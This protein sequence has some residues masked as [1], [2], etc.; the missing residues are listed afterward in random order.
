MDALRQNLRFGLRQ[1]WRSPLFTVAAVATLAL[2]IGANTALFTL[3]S[4]IMTKPLPGIGAAEQLVWIMAVDRDSRPRGLSYPDFLDYRNGLAGVQL[5]ATSEAEF[6]VS[7]RG[8]PERVSG[9]AVSGNYF[10]TVR[11]PFA[12]GRGFIPGEDSIGN[13]QPVVVLS[14]S[15][16]LRRFAGDSSVVG[17]RVTVNGMPLT[18]VG[19]VAEGFNGADIESPR[20][21]WIPMATYRLLNPGFSLDGRRSRWMK[22]LGRMPDGMTPAQLDPAVRTVAA[23]IAA[24]DSAGHFGMT[25]RA[26]SAKAGLPP[27]AEHE[28]LPVAILAT[29]VTGLVLLIACANVSNLLLARGV[30]RRREIGIRLSIGATRWRLVSQLLT[31]SLL[32]AAL[33]AA[34]GV[35][36]AY[37]STDYLLTSGIL[38]LVFDV[39][40]DTRVVLFT[41]GAAAL[42]AVMFGLVPAIE[43]TRTNLV[44]AVKDGGSGRDPRRSRLQSTFVVAQLSLS[45]VLLTTAGLFLRSLYKANNVDIGYD[46]T[47]RV[48]ALSFDL[49]LQGYSESRANAFL[50][51]IGTRASGL[52][53]V[54]G[55]SFTDIPPMGNRYNIGSLHLDGDGANAQARMHVNRVSVRPGYFT[56]IGT[57]LMRG[58]DF[59]SSDDRGAPRVVIVSQD[60]AAQLWPGVD[61]IGKR[62]GLQGAEGPMVT[63]VGVAS[64]VML[65]GPTEDQRSTVY[66]PQTQTPS[67]N[68]LTMLVRS[69]GDAQLLSAA[70]RR[71]F[72]ALDADLPLADVQ[73]LK[74]YKEIKLSS[75]M[76]GASILAGFGGL[77]LVLAA[78]GIFGV[79]AFSVVQR[80]REIGI[81][82]AL[83]AKTSEV[84]ALFLKRGM[85]LTMIGIAI[86]LALSLAVSRVM[87]GLLFGLTP[88]DGATFVGVAALLA[89]VALLACWLPARRAARVDPLTALRYE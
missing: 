86:G 59:A 20:A 35:L 17:R 80:T 47:S 82:I 44:S 74:Q 58:R 65:G 32:L 55:V 51:S 81:R 29:L 37:L 71:E 83:G 22:A 53:G 2:G 66:V 63:V 31:E 46:A 88:T 26:Y 57:R 48:L 25:A 34:A 23:R 89:A 64:N 85:R 21:V 19:V 67:Q 69:A 8:T 6:S 56:L 7:G 27:G 50:S 78:I 60:M 79:M 39:T 1:M 36:L 24:E 68:R 61:P 72:T 77:A 13:A 11:A 49:G 15:F 12:V 3:V 40:P 76:H 10:T 4:A 62:I 84:V 33:S 14:H 70:L 42:A 28:A 45:L 73:T 5:A 52:P 43:A 38:P 16:W 75:R 18:V 9:Q 54:E 87:H 30:A 41:A